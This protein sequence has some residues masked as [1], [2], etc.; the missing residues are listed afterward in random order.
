MGIS[1]VAMW[2]LYHENDVELFYFS[3]FDDPW[4]VAYEGEVG[5]QWDL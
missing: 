5:A 2:Q 4:K 3:S 1:F